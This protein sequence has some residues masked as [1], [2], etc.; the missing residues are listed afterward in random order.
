AVLVRRREPRGRPAD[1]VVEPA[2]AGSR[3]RDAL[4]DRGLGEAV[5]AEHLTRRLQHALAGLRRAAPLP[6]GLACHAH[7]LGRQNSRIIFLTGVTR[8]PNLFLEDYSRK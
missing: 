5:L 8:E 4:R 7:I 1:V 2:D 6:R 3:A